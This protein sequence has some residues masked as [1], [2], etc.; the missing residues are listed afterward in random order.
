VAARS[1]RR[2]SGGFDSSPVPPILT[3]GVVEPFSGRLAVRC[4][5]SVQL[6][7]DEQL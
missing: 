5:I 6:V 2:G 7:L 1:F 4:A 3:I